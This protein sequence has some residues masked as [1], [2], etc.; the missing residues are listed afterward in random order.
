M[1]QA[2]LADADSQLAAERQRLTNMRMQLEVDTAA[3]RQQMLADK[4]QQD[5]EMA[6]KRREQ[7][8]GLAAA[9]SRQEAEIAAGQT[10]LET[11][12]AAEAERLL[13]WRRQLDAD[14][15]E[16]H[17]YAATVLTLWAAAPLMVPSPMPVW[18]TEKA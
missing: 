8:A 1:Q 16:L 2:E 10:R 5:Q 13:A 11:D 6:E 17:R 3:G 12:V 14:T 15:H 9:R 18:K 4:R 7:E